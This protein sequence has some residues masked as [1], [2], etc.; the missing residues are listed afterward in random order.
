VDWAATLQ[1][2]KPRGH[3]PI[4]EDTGVDTA[5]LAAFESKMEQAMS[6]VQS[7]V[8]AVSTPLGTQ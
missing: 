3:A 8:R 4:M 6:R 1:W 5:A 2:K 7:Q